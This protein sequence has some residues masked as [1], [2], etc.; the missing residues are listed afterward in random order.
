MR[1][2]LLLTVLML[3][4]PLTGCIGGDETVDP[5][6]LPDGAPGELPSKV[7]LPGG[8]DTDL[9]DLPAAA[10]AW[11]A[12]DRSAVEPTLGFTSDGTI[13]YAAAGFEHGPEVCQGP[14]CAQLPAT[15]LLRSSDGGQT[16]EDV[17]PRL[18]NG[19]ENPPITGDPYVYVDR[20]TDRVFM[21]DMNPPLTCSQLSFSD[22]K[23]ETWTTQPVACTGNPPI[24]D[25]QTI[26]SGPPAMTPT[27]GYENVVY[28]CINRIT[29]SQC[30]RSL[31]GGLTFSSGTPVFAG[32]DPQQA[33]VSAITSGDPGQVFSGAFEGLC[34]GLHGHVQVSPT[35]GTVILPRNHCGTPMVGLSQDDGL[36]WETVEVAGYQTYSGHEAAVAFD[37]AGNAYF[38]TMEETGRM[39][40]SI[41]QDSG[42]TW[43]DPIDVTH[44]DVT[45]AHLPTIA[46]GDEGNVVVAYTGTENL[47]MGYKNPDFEDG[48]NS[49]EDEA[50]NNATWNGYIGV[51]TDALADQPTIQTVLVNHPS[52]PLVRGY[53]GPGRCPGM[54]DFIDVEVSPDGRPYAAFVDACTGICDTEDGTWEHS[55]GGNMS[56]AGAVGTLQTGPALIG[57]GSLD[58]LPQ[59]PGAA[60]ER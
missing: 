59:P 5:A 38:V 15:H 33:N 52:E 56:F 27:A 43:S 31:D 57:G 9:G 35:D 12:L 21:L 22:D 23:G 34:G 28:Q 41:S 20:T 19:D 29:D 53:C 46:A 17:T 10:G 50:I 37:A 32:Y 48:Y 42:Q 7:H 24:Y 54:Y 25:H 30:A 51:I 44:P 16:W 39:M 13:F 2:W 11:L 18:P 26:N 45:A 6:S 60:T 40:L 55:Q 58:P 1:A 47:P 8:V 4:A 14:V 49:S 3:G 36:T